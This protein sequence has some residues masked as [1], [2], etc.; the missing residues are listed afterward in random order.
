MTYSLDNGPE[1]ASHRIILAHGAGAGITFPFLEA[2]ASLLADRG[3]AVTRFEFA[4]MAQRRDGGNKRPPPKVDVLAQEYAA[5]IAAVTARKA[6]RQR[7]VIGGKSLGGRVASLI[8][9]DQ[10]AA[11]RIGGLVCLGYPFHAPATP[12]K[13]RTA[14]LETLACPALIVQ[15]TRDPFGS[16]PEV[17]ALALS[18]AIQVHWIGDGDHD[19]GPRGASGF[20]R[21]GNLADAADAVATFVRT[22]L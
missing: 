22:R 2:M 10:Y 6:D 16:Q 8:A 19:F 9:G 3:L 14:H 21:T 20:T 15:G 13:L 7:L 5:M 17:E 11:G 12:E 4:Y 18:P 1:N